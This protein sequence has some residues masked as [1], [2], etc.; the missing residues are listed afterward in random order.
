MAEMNRDFTSICKNLCLEACFSHARLIIDRMSVAIL[1]NK[2]GVLCCSNNSL[3]IQFSIHRF[4]PWDLTTPT[5]V[6]CS[7]KFFP[8]I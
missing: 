7:W 3:S 8:Y 6:E 4:G 5:D 2:L 1:K